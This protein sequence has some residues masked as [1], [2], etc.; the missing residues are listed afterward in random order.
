MRLS[1][2]KGAHVAPLQ[3]YVRKIRGQSRFWLEWGSSF[4]CKPYRA[5][6]S[7]PFSTGDAQLFMWILSH[8]LPSP[9]RPPADRVLCYR[10]Q[11]PANGVSLDSP[12]P[13]PEYIMSAFL[14]DLRYAGR[15]LAKSPGFAAIAILT[16]A[17]GI[18]ADTTLFSVVNGVLLNPLAY[19]GSGRLVS[20]NSNEAVPQ[21][22]VSYPNFLDWQRQSRTLSPMAMYRHEDY[23][24]TNHHGPAQRVNG[25]MVSAPFFT[26]LGV[27]P[28]FGRDFDGSD[29]RLGAAPVALLSDGFWHRGFGGS[30]SVL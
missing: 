26:T 30:L 1:L 18:A 29:D 13:L 20:I 14:Q 11:H 16:L 27:H 12:P 19:P 10:H 2:K 28:A 23:N 17:L 22:P 8:N 3:G 4:R 25:F 15:M 5:S 6:S 9:R 7:R 21:I 24:F